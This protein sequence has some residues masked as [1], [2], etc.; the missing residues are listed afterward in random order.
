MAGRVRDLHLVLR[1]R[2][3]AGRHLRDPVPGGLLRV[4]RPWSR[5]GTGDL[6]EGPPAPEDGYWRG[7]WG[8][9][10][11]P[12]PP[13]HGGG[14][15]EA[16]GPVHC[17]CRRVGNRPHGHTFP[18]HP[19]NRRNPD[20]LLLAGKPVAVHAGRRCQHRWALR[21]RRPARRPGRRERC[22]EHDGLADALARIT[23]EGRRKA[24]RC[25]TRRR[26][27]TRLII[28]AASWRSRRTWSTARRRGRPR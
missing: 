16:L 13:L 18:D 25:R 24:P 9:V 21:G 19:R 4:H 22:W 8:G 23:H 17:E 26:K 28:R 5:V 27:P 6:R 2:R 1:R 3:H 12:D 15:H 20:G 11:P 7:A 10:R 14:R